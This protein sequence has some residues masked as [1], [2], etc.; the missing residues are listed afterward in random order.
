MSRGSFTFKSSFYTTL[1][2]VASHSN[3]QKFVWEGISSL[4]YKDLISPQYGESIEQKFFMENIFPVKRKNLK[5][6]LN[7]PKIH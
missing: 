6:N 5:I 7:N 1:K 3:F 4:V 2:L